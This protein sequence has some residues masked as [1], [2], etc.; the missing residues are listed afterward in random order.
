MM[1]MDVLVVDDEPDIRVTLSEFLRDEG[2]GVI[3]LDDGRLL[4]DAI[5]EHSPSLV[6]LDLTMPHF[7]PHE[8][9]RD[10]EARGLADG[11]TILAMSGL[12]DAD[13]LAVELGLAGV[14]RKPFEIEALLASVKH[15]CRAP[16]PTAEVVPPAPALDPRNAV[17]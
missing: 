8:T 9:I 13:A 15:F 5:A 11:T 16:A 2:Y 1:G 7:N 12:E 17:E 14:V 4:A 10:V 3:E 6:L